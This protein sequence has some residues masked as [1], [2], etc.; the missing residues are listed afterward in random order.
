MATLAEPYP[1]PQAVPARPVGLLRWVT[2]VDHK[3]IGILYLLTTI[4]FFVIG[5]LEALLIRVQL[6]VPRNTF[7]GPA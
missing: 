2:T 4:V 6:A 1:R 5:G 7:L 3:D